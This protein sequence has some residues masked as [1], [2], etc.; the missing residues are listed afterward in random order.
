[1]KTD[2]NSLTL[3]AKKIL[4]ENGYTCVFINNEKEIYPEELRIKIKKQYMPFS[5][6]VCIAILLLNGITPEEL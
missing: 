6:M 3:K 2:I 5:V 1:M 4:E